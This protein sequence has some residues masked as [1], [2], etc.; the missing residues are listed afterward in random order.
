MR[1]V[2]L[3]CSNGISG[4]MLL[5]ALLDTGLDIEELRQ[6]L[7]ALPVDGYSINLK[8]IKSHS[9][10]TSRLMV[11]VG[12]PQTFRNLNDITTLL[13]KSMV[14]K[15]IKNTSRKIFRRLA[16]AEAHV[17]GIGINDVHFHEIGAVDTII[18]VVG[19]VWAL[20]K[21]KIK[22]V[23]SS[24]VNVGSGMVKTAHGILPVPAPA[25][26]ELLKGIPVYSTGVKQELATPTGAVLLSSLC[27][28]FQAIPKMR[29]DYVG[30]SSGTKETKG[31][32]NFFRVFVGESV[33]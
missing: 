2:Y 6:V 17:H 19:T 4:D 3:D 30:M 21:L 8:K 31:H 22:K 23:Y 7:F 18:D 28:A 32:S 11:R 15:K 20:E 9:L 13:E 27:S 16:I 5:A 29:V 24:P 25:T 14:P 12:K 10:I 33:K 26:A 1:I